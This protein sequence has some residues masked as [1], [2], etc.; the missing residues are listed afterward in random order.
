MSGR[1]V[2]S[3]ME[4]NEK[5][6][7]NNSGHAD[8]KKQQQQVEHT[9]FTHT[10]VKAPLIHPAP[11]IIST[12]A[13]GLAE[14]IV[15]QGFTASAA[16]I[17]GGTAEVHL[18]PS[19]AMTEE[20]RRDQERYRQEQ[21]SIA[22]QQEREMEKKTEAYRKTA[23]AEAEKIRKELEKQHARD[24]E[25][26]KD[27]I[28]STIDRQ[29]REVDLEAKMAKRELDR[30]GQ[31]A[32][33]ALERSRLATNVEVNFDSAAGHT[34]SGGTTVSTSDKMEIKRN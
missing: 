17:S 34:V 12:G 5:V 14:E 3:H 19:A 27:L 23:E 1:N 6:V 20:A 30:E 21:E 13:A 22:K 33:E 32:K 11:P 28:E 24:V 18:Q 15:G 16:R 7:V 4:R 26:R 31:L 25:F 8:V 10:E 2:E 29:K 9:E